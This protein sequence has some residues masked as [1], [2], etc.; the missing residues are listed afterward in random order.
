[1]LCCFSSIPRRPRDSLP[2][3]QRHRAQ[4]LSPIVQSD[5]LT[6]VPVLPAIME[7]SAST[8]KKNDIA[9]LLCLKCRNDGH[10]ASNCPSRSWP[11]DEFGWFISEQRRSL[12]VGLG[13]TNYDQELCERCKDLNILQLL[14]EGLP[15]ETTSDLNKIAARGILTDHFQSIGKAGTIEFWDDCPLCICLFAMTPNPSLATQDVLLITDWT[16]NRLAGETPT[17]KD[18]E[19]W[20]QFP[21]CLLI[22][23]SQGSTNITF[24]TRLHR[25]DA[26]CVVEEDDP[27]HMLGGRII[28]PDRIP[29]DIIKTWLTSCDKLHTV[30]CRPMWT[31]ELPNLKL[32]EVSTRKIVQLPKRPF[33]YIALSYVWGGVT[34]PSFQLG[35]ELKEKLPQTIEDTIDLVRELGKQFL[36]V[37]S[38]C[39]DQKDDKD[40]EKQIMAMKDIYSGAYVTI[41]ALSGKSADAGLPRLKESKN[42]F[43]QLSCRVKGKRLVGLMPTLS[44]QIWRAPWGQRAWTLQEAL[45]APRCLYISDHQLNFECNGMQ[46]SESLNDSRSWAHHLSLEHSPAQ[47]GWLASKV[48]DGCLRTPIDLPSH[49]LERYGSKLTL[50]SYRSMTNPADG[51]NAFSGILQFLESMYPKSFYCGLPIED[52][53]WGLLWRSQ[54]PPRRRAGFP[55]WSWSG[56]QGG[57]FPAYPFDFTKTNEHPLHIR[58]WRVQKTQLVQ[59]FM[60]THVNTFL[61]DPITRSSGLD[62]GGVGFDLL[63]YPKAEQDNYLFIEAIMLKFTPDFSRPLRDDYNQREESAFIFS[64]RGAVCYLTIMSMDAEVDQPPDPEGKQFILLARDYSEK[65]NLVFHHLLMVHVLGEIAVRRTVLDL[66]VP[67]S[68]LDVLKDFQPQKRRLV[69]A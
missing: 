44:Q 29:T 7:A 46:C 68:R 26:L 56:W 24:N 60:S 57:L 51:L 20:N 47:G 13:L 4:L 59:F 27:D 63:Q 16:M 31:Q 15:W 28:S 62:I 17:V 43:P 36:W 34:Q 30:K 64:I 55:T 48:G 23:L 67:V 37:D 49:R 12:S 33:D 9:K 53:Q 3:A 35:S 22:A 40:K 32:V 66:V 38:L 14:K 50:Y 8:Q 54:Y 10:N 11:R 61:N 18:L 65:Q 2:Q 6:T 19:G 1:M 58:L 25:G 42:M 21:K 45:L 39:I 5:Q 69:M 52:Y 41:I